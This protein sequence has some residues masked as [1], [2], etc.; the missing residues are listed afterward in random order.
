MSDLQ[1]HAREFIR[2]LETHKYEMSDQGIYIPGAKVF[3]QGVFGHD[4]NGQDYREDHNLVV[5]EGLMYLL[6][7]GLN[8][9]TPITT[10]YMSLYAANYTPVAG[11]TQA[12]YPATASEIT[13]GTEGYSEA[14]RQTWVNAAPSANA[15]SNVASKA[16]FT[17]VTASSLDVNG[18]AMN[19]TSTKGDTTG[20]L[21][22]A[23]KFSATRT[24]LNA[25]VFNLS[26]TLQLT[27]S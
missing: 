9:G 12:S 1:R 25:D 3:V 11:L 14:V 5:S 15:I 17:I 13:S 22:A 10:W 27:A 23:S 19:S 20:T 7:A 8:G 18:A 2:A 26:Y 21:L 24:L 16:A 4:V 6:S